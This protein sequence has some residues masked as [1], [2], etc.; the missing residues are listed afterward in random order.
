MKPYKYAFLA[1]AAACGLAQAA[2]TAYTTPV[3]YSSLALTAGYNVPGLSLQTPTLA[4][5]AFSAVSGTLLTDATASFAPTSGRL[6]VLE[7]TS[8]TLVGT[9]QEVPA[10]SI[11]ATTLTTTDDLQVAGLQVGDKY[12]LRVAPTLEE[13]FGTTSL[14]NG[15]VLD[16]ALSVGASDVIWVPNGSGGFD[17][18]YLRTSGAPPVGTFRSTPANVNTPN[19]PVVYADGMFIEKKAATPATLT[20]SGEVKTQGTNSTI[21]FGYNLVNIVAPVGLNL[22]NAGLEDN[23]F[24]A[25]SVGS[26]DEVWVLEANK[27]W[28]KYYRRSTYTP[29]AADSGWRIAGS[30][31]ANTPI[32]EAQ[33][34]AIALPS[35]IM[36]NK[37]NA[38]TVPLTLNVP[39]SYSGL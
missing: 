19:V 33:A 36:I 35:T 37:K 23:L 38:G 20:V 28:S 39:T 17:K 22:L 13:I 3:G 34:A 31:P 15:G 8:G 30:V 5:G 12:K 7:I 32:T 25:L 9:I 18:Y 14:A 1:A 2:D 29:S 26:A 6:Y 24:P 21:T 16:S 11:T 27:S 4:A 10:A